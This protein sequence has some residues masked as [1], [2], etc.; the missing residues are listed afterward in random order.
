M[1]SAA[2]GQRILATGFCVAGLCEAGGSEWAGFTDPG[3][4]FRERMPEPVSEPP[5]AATAKH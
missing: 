2:G 5:A 3:Y 4:N 1:N